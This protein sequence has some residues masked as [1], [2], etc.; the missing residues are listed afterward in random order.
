[1]LT[2]AVQRGI[3]FAICWFVNVGANLKTSKGSFWL[4]LLTLETDFD[5]L[6]YL[7][8]LIKESLL[9]CL[10]LNTEISM[11]NFVNEIMQTNRGD[12]RVVSQI[13]E[14][15]ELNFVHLYVCWDDV[16]Q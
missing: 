12:D 13:L 5:G 2:L 3:L 9:F 15:A 11:Q 16:F 7:V 1:M 4:D 14:V 8:K 10:W 6:K